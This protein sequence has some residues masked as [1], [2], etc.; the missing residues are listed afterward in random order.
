MNDCVKYKFKKL[1]KIK[2]TYKYALI[3]SDSNDMLDYICNMN[4]QNIINSK[5]YTRN[6][7]YQ[8]IITTRQKCDKNL[9]H[10]VFKDKFHID[11]IKSNC[12]LICEKNA[13]SKI[14]KAFKGS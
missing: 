2:T 9:K 4:I 8:L 1:K 10:I 5:L 7:A 3:F 11:E 14:Q 6:G 13:V 12:R